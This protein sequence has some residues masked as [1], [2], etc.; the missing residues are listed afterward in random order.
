M[1]PC[2]VNLFTDPVYG[3]EDMALPKVVYGHLKRRAGHRNIY[4]LDR[5]LQST[6]NMA[7]FSKESVSFIAR[8]KENRKQVEQ[9][10]IPFTN[11]DLGTLELIHDCKVYLYTGQPVTNKRGNKHYRQELVEEPLRLIVGRSKADPAAEYWFI[12]N[13]F[14]LTAKEITDAYRRRWA[15][16]VFFRFIKQELNASHFI[17][18]NKN[19]IEVILY[20]ILITAML[21]LIYKRANNIGY[22]TAKRWFA[23]DVRDLTI[24]MIV[25]QCGGD[26]N[27]FFKTRKE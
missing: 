2:G 22:K 3:S 18:L 4:V 5:G 8:A 23:M 1:L 6:R 7:A 11:T 24:A 20:M 26:P 17:S 15:I 27:I 16:E 21:V 19:G 25:V 14:E 10:K 12:T 13:V 9:E